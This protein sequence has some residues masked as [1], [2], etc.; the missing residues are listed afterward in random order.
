MLQQLPRN[1]DPPHFTPIPLLLAACL[2]SLASA[3][4]EHETDEGRLRG[5]AEAVDTV[6]FWLGFVLLVVVSAVETIASLIWTR[7]RVTSDGI[8]P[9]E[10]SCRVCG[11]EIFSMAISAGEAAEIA[12]RGVPAGWYTG[13]QSIVTHSK[14]GLATNSHGK[15]HG[16]SSC[17][18][19]EKRR[20]QT[21]HDGVTEV[22]SDMFASV[23]LLPSLVIR[24]FNP[25]TSLQAPTTLVDNIKALLLLLRRTEKGKEKGNSLGRTMEYVVHLIVGLL[26]VALGVAGLALYSA[27]PE[28]L[29]ETLKDPVAPMTFENYLTL[30]LLYWLLGGVLLVFM[31]PLRSQ[32]RSIQMFGWPAKV[33]F[34]VASLASFA[35]FCVG[36]WKMDVARRTG[37]DWTP[38]LSYWIGGAS[39]IGF[40]VCGIEL[41]HTFGVVG[42]VFMLIHTF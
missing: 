30:F 33:A 37:A 40:P 21:Y 42:L 39:A 31:I 24:R 26:D 6:G 1:L 29:Y 15:S 25:L 41:F 8:H 18:G 4:T 22:V 16:C 19:V 7:I 9:P 35:L 36:C 3:E 34:V 23:Q 11:R 13:I 5:P 38:M 12:E 10:L 27:S 28:R 20:T 2:F 17:G 14:L 32:R